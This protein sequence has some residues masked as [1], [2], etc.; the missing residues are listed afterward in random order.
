MAGKLHGRNI[1]KL[2]PR[3]VSKSKLEESRNPAILIIMNAAQIIDE[4]QR[5]PEEERGKVVEFIR[6]HPNAETIAAIN[7]PIEEGRSFKSAEELFAAIDSE[8]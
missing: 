3:S 8:D 4:I 5:L 7:E 2:P 6:H 1:C